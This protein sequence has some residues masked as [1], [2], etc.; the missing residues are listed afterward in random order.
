[1]QNLAPVDLHDMI[2]SLYSQYSTQPA[3]LDRLRHGIERVLPA[4]LQSAEAALAANSARRQELAEGSEEFRVSFMERNNYFY[5]SYPEV[6]I[7]YDGNHFRACSQDDIQHQILSQITAGGAL[8]PWK[9][10]VTRTLIKEIR[11]RS[12]LDRIPESST[13][14][15]TLAALV[16]RFF[17]TREAAK[18]FLTVVG[19]GIRGLHQ[20]Q[21]LI[22]LTPPPLR[23]LV[24][25]L[26]V[27]VFTHTG[28]GS[29]LQ[30]LKFKHHDHAY[31]KCRLLPPDGGG[32]SSS[33][34]GGLSS[35]PRMSID[36]LC[37]A[38][39]YSK[40]FDGADSYL[41]DHCHDSSLA[42]YA[43][44]LANTTPE[45][46]VT[47]FVKDCIE[48]CAQRRIHTK[49]MIFVWK[50]YL[51]RRDL[52]SVIFY[53]ALKDMLR[54][55][56]DYSAE[57]DAFLGVTSPYVPIVAAFLRFWSESIV[58]DPQA[59]DEE[60]EIDEL[61]TLFRQWARQQGVSHGA[62]DPCL[63]DLIKHFYPEVDIVDE[64][65][66]ANVRC[67]LWDK[68]GTVR[69]AVDLYLA[70]CDKDSPPTLSAAYAAYVTMSSHTKARVS[71]RFFEKN[72]REMLGARVDKEGVISSAGV[73]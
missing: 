28:S 3:I 4:S 26:S 64:R 41:Q 42:R 62:G 72:A 67:R 16:P 40:R 7:S 66:L 27:E 48:G 33:S 38:C 14:Q 20:D 63:L 23:D 44:Q 49:N 5:L 32:P 19:D 35:V 29:A 12:P 11:S 10:K 18:Y 43:L 73:G 47:G 45:G 30:C 51:A 54:S 53:G 9:H 58:E 55:Q 60:L 8:R 61:R 22:Y 1:M 46:L 17:K 69:D 68:Q 13:I 31:E 2:D 71:K 37:V 36:I 50:Q 6:F 57:E 39:H 70:G 25:S 56:L 65:V 21:G 52:P 34:H 24:R 15:A 59:Q